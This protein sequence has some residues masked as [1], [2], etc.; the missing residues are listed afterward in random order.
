MEAERRVPFAEHVFLERRI[1]E[2]GLPRT[3]PI[4]RFISLVAQG[5]SLNPH[6]SVE[7]KHAHL[8]WFRDYLSVYSP[9]SYSTLYMPY[10][11]RYYE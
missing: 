11:V 4:G 6:L 8:R 5:L 2:F 10:A 1:A 9:F 3:G 7:E